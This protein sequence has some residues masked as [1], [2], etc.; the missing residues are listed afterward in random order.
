MK[1][2]WF[3]LIRP[4]IR[5][6]FLGVGGLGGG[7]LDSHD[8]TS[9]NELV[10]PLKYLSKQG[11]HRETFH[12][13]IKNAFGVGDLFFSLLRNIQKIVYSKGLG[14]NFFRI[15]GNFGFPS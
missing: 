2:H 3:P 10:D 7:T 6:L 8:K 4:A 12:Q 5:A 15:C 9:L 1:T 11:N 13:K 14:A